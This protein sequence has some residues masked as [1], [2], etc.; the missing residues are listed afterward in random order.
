MEAAC[1]VAQ[2][3]ALCVRRV[4]CSQDHAGHGTC[5]F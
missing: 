3:V 4:T 2:I 5:V 1:P